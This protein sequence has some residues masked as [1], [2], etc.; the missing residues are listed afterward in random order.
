M[1]LQPTIQ[2]AAG[3]ISW[4]ALPFNHLSDKKRVLVPL[5]TTDKTDNERTV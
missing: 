5:P 1:A 3:A 4:M 2:T